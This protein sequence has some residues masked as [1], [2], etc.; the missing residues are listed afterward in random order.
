MALGKN[1]KALRA[2]R[3]WRLKDLS[4][5]SGVDVG[6]IGAL[7]V[8]DSA[9]SEHA[10]KLAKAFDLSLDELLS[11]EFDALGNLVNRQ[12]IPHLGDEARPGTQNQELRSNVL[13]VGLNKSLPRLAWHEVHR[14]VQGMFKPPDDRYEVVSAR[15][16]HDRCFLLEVSGDAMT[17]PL[18]DT[19]PN[20]SLLICDPDQEVKPGQLVIAIHPK[21]GEPVFRR[22]V[23]DGGVWF[24]KASNAAYPLIEIDGPACVVARV[25]KVTIEMDV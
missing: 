11:A 14:F 19:F 18:A 9:K 3:K 16:V 17:G 24:L 12:G 22:L 6:T 23:L 5:L 1:V 10:P 2:A 13:L 20:G 8:R 15:N 4:A 25:V 7:E 21:S